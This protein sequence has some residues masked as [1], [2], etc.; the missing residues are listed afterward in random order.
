[1]PRF[2]TR[3]SLSNR[4]G[5]LGSDVLVGKRGIFGDV[6]CL[7]RRQK[8]I[9]AGEMDGLWGRGLLS[10]PCERGELVGV[11]REDLLIEI[12]LDDE[13]RLLDLLHY[14]SRLEEQQALEPRRVCLRPQLRRNRFPAL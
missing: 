11:M 13:N 14:F 10:R 2:P 8:M 12:S 5:D 1:M 6:P 7:C 4:F 3:T 9:D